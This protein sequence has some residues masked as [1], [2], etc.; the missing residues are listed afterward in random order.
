[1]DLRSGV[2]DP[3][4]TVVAVHLPRLMELLHQEVVDLEGTVAAVH[5]PL[6]MELLH[7]EV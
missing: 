5:L 3:E 6:L 7:Q 2:A 1:M 4:V